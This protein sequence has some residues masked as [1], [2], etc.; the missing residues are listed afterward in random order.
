MDPI[1]DLFNRIKNA[2]AVNK[3]ATFA[4]YSKLKERILQILKD[5]GFILDYKIRKVNNK[6]TLKIYLKYDNNNQGAIRG[7]KQ[8][9]KPGRR[10]YQKAKEIKRVKSGYGIAIISTSKGLITDKEA[11]KYKV[12]GEVI[13]HIW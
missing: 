6:K 2:Q 1:N 12:G 13:A 10:I 11:R 4:P 3:I 7:I 5:N 8:I 9:S